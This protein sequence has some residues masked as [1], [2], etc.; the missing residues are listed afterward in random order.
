MKLNKYVLKIPYKTKIILYNTVNDMIVLYSYKDFFSKRSQEILKNNGFYD[1]NIDLLQRYLKQVVK[2][3]K[4][5]DITISLT[6]SCNLCC[7]YCSQTSVKKK[8]YI[9]K[10]VLDDIVEYIKICIK[11]YG[12]KS[13]AIHLFGGEPLLMQKEIFYLNTELE[14]LNVSTNYYMDTNGV[15]LKKEFIRKLNNITFCI[16]LSEKIDHDN[17]R[18]TETNDGTYDV[19]MKNIKDVQDVLDDSHKMMIRYNVNHLN[20]DRLEH[21]LKEIRNFRI[22]D[23]VVAYTDNY[24]GN[25]KTNKL[26]YK[27]YKKWNSTKVI[28]LLIKYGYPIELPTSSY[29]CKGYERYSIKIF[30]DGR[31]GMC[32]AYDINKANTTLNKIIADYKRT[33]ILK[34]NF[35]KER[36]FSK[37]IDNQCKK[38]KYLYICNGKYFCRENPCEFLDYNIETYIK[39][40]VKNTLK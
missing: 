29:Y 24:D 35:K 15:L 37:I 9:S 1:N 10:Q 7:K 32:N 16:T 13:L 39:T 34:E 12:Y 4:Q 19:I 14:K 17:L 33:H 11:N 22:T 26:S 3:R 21:F 31:V 25:V 6:E 38:C 18:L 5:L 8:A 28:P 30:S 20:I 36:D 27:Q 23:I 2:K 40:Y